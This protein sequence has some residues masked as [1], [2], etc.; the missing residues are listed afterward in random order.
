MGLSNRPPLD[1]EETQEALS[2]DAVKDL[3]QALHQKLKEH[4]AGYVVFED[5]QGVPMSVSFIGDPL[6]R[7]R[8]DGERR[9]AK[10]TVDYNTHFN[11]DGAQREPFPLG[12]RQV[13]E[14]HVFPEHWRTIISGFWHSR[15]EAQPVNPGDSEDKSI[16]VQDQLRQFV[17]EP[18]ATAKW[19]DAKGEELS[20]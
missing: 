4:G 12:V 11:P 20:S 16:H 10:L 1:S 15:G 2:A 18:P 19:F 5:N 14:L 17:T 9:H 13:F 8:E 6:A 7:E 3:M